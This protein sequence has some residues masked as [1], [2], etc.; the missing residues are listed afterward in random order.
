MLVWIY[1]LF[2]APEGT[3]LEIEFIQYSNVAIQAL[4]QVVHWH[5]WRPRSFAKNGDGDVR[6]LLLCYARA[7]DGVCAVSVPSE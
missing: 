1:S 5:I 4:Y 2:G 3:F 6:F 7:R